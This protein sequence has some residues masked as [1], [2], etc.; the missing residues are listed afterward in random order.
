MKRLLY[1]DYA[2]AIAIILVVVGHY[3]P[4]IHPLWY[5]QMRTVIYGFHMP[6]FMFTSG[7]IYTATIRYEKYI[8][9][10]HRKI[11]R[12]MI[13]YFAVS[14][15]IITIKLLTQN[16]SYVENPATAISYLRMLYLPEAGYYTWFIWALWWMFVITP[17]FDTKRKR[18]GLLM[19]GIILYFLPFSFPEFFCLNEFKRFLIFF[20]LGCSTWDYKYIVKRVESIPTYIFFALFII[21]NCICMILFKNMLWRLILALTGI[22]FTISLC[23]WIER[24]NMVFYSKMF[25]FVASSSYIIYLFHTTFEGFAKAILYKVPVFAHLQND[26]L[27]VISA[28]I[29]ISCGVIIPILCDVYIFKRYKFTRFLLGYN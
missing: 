26:I 20:C 11:R 9:F 1:I 12:L 2:K 14:T 10:L 29:V 15:L 16:N 24:R 27:F 5:E 23:K 22:G 3:Y 6:L 28:F 7:F 21:A 13:P 17:C 18:L 19:L 4:D 8:S 25:S